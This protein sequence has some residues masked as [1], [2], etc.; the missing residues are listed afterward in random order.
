MWAMSTLGRWPLSF[1]SCESLHEAAIQGRGCRRGGAGSLAQKQYCNGAER[2][3]V[4][5]AETWGT[6]QQRIGKP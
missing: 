5:E 1:C 2:S 6:A 3:G 4:P